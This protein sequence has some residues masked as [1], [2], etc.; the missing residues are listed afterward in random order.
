[1]GVAKRK[2]LAG[3]C[4]SCWGPRVLRASWTVT[5][6]EAAGP[7]QPWAWRLGTP[8]SWPIPLGSLGRQG[9]LGSPGFLP[10][11]SASCLLIVLCS[12]R[13]TLSFKEGHR[14]LSARRLT[15]V[16]DS[17]YMTIM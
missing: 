11:V 17:R 14:E 13:H 12:S 2:M 7:V 16:Y 4:P 5:S 15:Q 8:A 6:G 1:M 9:G 3:R 10:H